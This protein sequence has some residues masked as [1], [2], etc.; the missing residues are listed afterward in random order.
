MIL[1]SFEYALELPMWETVAP[2]ILFERSQFEKNM[3][4][5][6]PSFFPI[7][8]PGFESGLRWNVVDKNGSVI[9]LFIVPQA[10]VPKTP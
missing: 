8:S 4:P 3:A 7:R 2:R 5:R 10:A 6:K 1:A 9:G